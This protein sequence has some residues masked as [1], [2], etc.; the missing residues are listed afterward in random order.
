MLQQG[1]LT[2]WAEGRVMGERERIRAGANIWGMK[3]GRK[4]GDG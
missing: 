2:E 3:K 4:N 1:N